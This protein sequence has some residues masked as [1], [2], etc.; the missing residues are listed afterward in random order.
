M[1]DTLYEEYVFAARGKG[2]SEKVIRDRHA[3]PNAI[4]PVLSRQIINLPILLSG[5][6]MIEE[7][8]GTG[9]WEP[10]CSTRCAITISPW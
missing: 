4:L 9:E 5:M 7:A 6:V 10:C 2:L 3:S 8:I 1:T